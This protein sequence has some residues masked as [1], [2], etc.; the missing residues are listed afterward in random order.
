M[1][2][3]EDSQVS[4]ISRLFSPAVIREMGRMGKS[5]LFSRLVLESLIFKSITPSAR[6]YDVFNFAFSILKKKAYRHEYVYKSALTQNILLGKHS[7]KTA[8]ML[9]EFRVGECKADLV[10]FNG[11][12]TVYEIKS[13]RDSLSRLERQISS[14]RQVFAKVYVI[15]GENHID[16]IFDTVPSDVGI[17]QLSRNRYISCIREAIEQPKRTDSAAIFDSIRLIEAQQILSFNGLHIPSVPNTELHS[18]LRKEFIKLPAETA[19]AG[20]VEVLKKTRNL[21]PLAELIEQ[22]PNSLQSAVLSVSLRKIDHERLLQAINVRLSDAM[23]W[24]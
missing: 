24:A 6:V 21:M 1:T 8:S 3:I 20:M 10:I 15:A 18:I 22:L 5:P 14:Y 19:H 13:E 11:T 17:M 7:L 4:A 12:S 2:K 23:S 9:T 16:T